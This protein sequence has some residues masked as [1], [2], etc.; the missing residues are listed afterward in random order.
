M[1]SG[2]VGVLIYGFS[3]LSENTRRRNAQKQERREARLCILPFLE[4]EADALAVYSKR[5]ALKG[6]SQLY[7]TSQLQCSHA[8]LIA[9][10]KQAA[11]LLRLSLVVAAP[12]LTAPSP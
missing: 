6:R 3:H 10:Y 4:A 2:G 9:V 5:S 8:S 7:S 1:H 12:L 11:P